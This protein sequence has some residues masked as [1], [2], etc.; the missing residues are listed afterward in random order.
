VSHTLPVSEAVIDR[1]RT[2]RRVRGM[3]AQE[4]ADRMDSFGYFTSRTG[5]ARAESGT[6]REIGVDWLYA[7]ARALGVE[8]TTLLMGPG[9]RS[10]YDAPPLGYTCKHCGKG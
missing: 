4:L 7:A 6:R 10:C 3:T 1:V 9:C 2:M 5:I 8:P